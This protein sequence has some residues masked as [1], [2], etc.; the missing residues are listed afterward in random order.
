MFELLSGNKKT[1]VL[2]IE[3]DTYGNVTTNAKERELS[4]LPTSTKAQIK[5]FLDGVLKQIAK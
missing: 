1:T 4:G 3:T 5:A 2:Y